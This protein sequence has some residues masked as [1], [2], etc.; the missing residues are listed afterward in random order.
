MSLSRA[1][2]YS[3]CPSI[4]TSLWKASEEITKEIILN[5]NKNLKRGQKKNR[6]LRTAKLKFL[7]DPSTSKAES[8]PFYWATF[9]HVGDTAEI[10]YRYQ[11]FWNL[12]KVVALVVC[13]LLILFLPYRL[14]Y[15]KGNNS[16]I[17]DI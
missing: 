8:H 3:G 1:F 16:K 13:L 14:F 11:N 12:I 7:K 5:F 10:V 4:V 15:R 6:A 17:T 2:M 9:I